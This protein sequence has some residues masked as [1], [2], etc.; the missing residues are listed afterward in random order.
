MLVS[1]GYCRSGEKRRRRDCADGPCSIATSPH[2][3]RRKESLGNHSMK[4]GN[5]GP[6]IILEET[7]FNREIKLKMQS[8]LRGGHADISLRIQ[9]GYV[10][11]PH[12]H[13]VTLLLLH[14]KPGSRPLFLSQA[15]P[16]D[17]RGRR[18]AA[19]VTWDSQE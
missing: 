3:T 11:L 9:P 7:S 12:P 17:P 14:Q 1:E 15:G 6:G 19:E 13:K 4:Q 10:C 2:M 18:K 5:G 8:P 16:G